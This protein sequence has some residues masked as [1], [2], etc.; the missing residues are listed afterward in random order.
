[1]KEL[2]LLISLLFVSVNVLN[3]QERKNNDDRVVERVASFAAQKDLSDSQ[4]GALLE[5][6]QQNRTAMEQRRAGASERPSEEE[7]AAFRAEARAR[8]L[9]ALD[10]NEELVDEWYSFQREQ[11][12][13]MHRERQ[14]KRLEK[15]E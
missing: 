4:K 13:T 2:V 1:M 6:V 11:R 12:K 9:Q 7:R 5:A 3:A 15:A 8:V 14:Q 10:H